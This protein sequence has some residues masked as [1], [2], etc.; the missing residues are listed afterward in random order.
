M[1]PSNENRHE[2]LLKVGGV[3][4]PVLYDTGA[5][6]TCLSKPTY[7]KYFTRFQRINHNA[8]VKGA[9]GNTLGLSGVYKIPVQWKNKKALGQFMVCDHL[10]LDLIGIDLINELGISYDAKAQQV[11]TISEEPNALQTTGEVELPALQTS[12]ITAR[13]TGHLTAYTTPVVTIA[14]PQHRHVTG[15]P[16]IVTFNEHN[17]CQVAITNTAPYPITLRR[18]EFLGSL[19]QWSRNDMGEP[20]PLDHKVVNQFIHK[21]EAKTQRLMNDQEI[22]EKANLNVP[23]STKLST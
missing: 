3:E 15:G 9:A 10:D 20:I 6:V 4:I 1:G 8:G 22:D 5:A 14:P 12:V 16:A 21:L 23:T 19:D 2:I 18:G 13:Y 17:V 11:F 7:E